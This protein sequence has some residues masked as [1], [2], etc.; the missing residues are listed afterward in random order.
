MFL[1]VMQIHQTL[2]IYFLL[3][4]LIHPITDKMIHLMDS[5]VVMVGELLETTQLTLGSTSI[6]VG[7]SIIIKNTGSGLAWTDA[8]PYTL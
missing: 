1:V 3:M 2:F 5:L 8:T 7:S 4:A 6:P